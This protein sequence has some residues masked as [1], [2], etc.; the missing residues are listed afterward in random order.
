MHDIICPHC[1]KDFSL[2]NA[3]CANIAKQVCDREFAQQLKE[4]LEAR[5]QEER[6]AAERARAAQAQEMQEDLHQR[7][8]EIQ[9][10]KNAL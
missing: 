4:K 8:T 2:D 7:D 5:A 10:L 1:H 6:L 3:G 9:T